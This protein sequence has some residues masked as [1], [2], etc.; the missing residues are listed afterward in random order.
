MAA[1]IVR[2]LDNLNVDEYLGKLWKSGHIS[3]D[4]LY[5]SLRE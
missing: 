1:S 2:D 5:F 4:S 3:F